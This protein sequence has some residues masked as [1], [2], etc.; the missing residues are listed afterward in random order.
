MFWKKINPVK[1][2]KKGSGEGIVIGKF[3]IKKEIIDLW[4]KIIIACLPAAI[5]GIKFDDVFEKLFYNPFSISIALISFG[6]LFILVET[7]IK[8]RDFK[9]T[10][11]KDITYKTAII[12]GLFQVL[13]AVFPGVSRSGAT[14]IGALLIG[15]SRSVAAEFTFFLAIPVMLGASLLKILKYGIL[16]TL[17]ELLLLLIGVVV[18]F[19]TSIIVIKYFMKYIK[20]KDFKIFGYYRIILGFIVLIAL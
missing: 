8:K 20:R 9:I 12:I 2:Y 15:V 14:I 13:A 5:I 10:D 3:I 18:S 11:L 17:S 1:K 19:V 16:F 4:I 7:Y 6:I